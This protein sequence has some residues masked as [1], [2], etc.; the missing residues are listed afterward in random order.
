MILS[1]NVFVRGVFFWKNS[2]DAVGA[3]LCRRARR[4][5]VM[6]NSPAVGSRN[7]NY[8]ITM[9]GWLLA[10]ILFS[11]RKHRTHRNA[12]ASRACHAGCVYS[13]L[14]G[15]RADIKW[16]LHLA[17]VLYNKLRRM[18]PRVLHIALKRTSFPYEI[19][20]RACQA[21]CVLAEVRHEARILLLW[22]TENVSFYEIKPLIL[23]KTSK[24][25]QF[26]SY[27]L[28]ISLPIK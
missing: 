26:L 19:E 11:H 21:E 17:R 27:F 8:E 5:G 23:R 9:L 7:L 18:V 6:K 22:R 28:K 24:S 20:L 1:K 13:P 25:V 16:P 2:A 10:E 3:T 15:R 12:L 14:M 4:N